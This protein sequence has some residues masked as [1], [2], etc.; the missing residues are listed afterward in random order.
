MSWKAQAEFRSASVQQFAPWTSYPQHQARSSDPY[1][2]INR[3]EVEGANLAPVGVPANLRSSIEP[4]AK[5][6]R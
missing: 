2:R 5:Y 1:T 3:A 6:L 4:I